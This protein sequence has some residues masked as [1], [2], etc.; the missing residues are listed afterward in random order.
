MDWIELAQIGTSGG[1]LWTRWWTFGFLKIWSSVSQVL[2]NYLYVDESFLRSGQLLSQSRN[3]LH[4]T[5]L[6]GSLPCTQHAVIGPYPEP[7]EFS[8]GPQL[9]FLKTNFT[10]ILSSTFRSS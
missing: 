3:S 6:E 8:L 1:L 9:Q 5:Q 4:F 10:S 7:D 2:T